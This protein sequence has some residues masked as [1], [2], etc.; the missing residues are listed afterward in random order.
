[1]TKGIIKYFNESRGY[2]FI[3]SD[4]DHDIYVHH[5]EIREEGYKT[6]R[7]GQVVRFDMRRGIRGLEA[8]NVHKI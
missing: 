8:V 6:L 3:K 4:E 2:G 7:E 1:M 5:S